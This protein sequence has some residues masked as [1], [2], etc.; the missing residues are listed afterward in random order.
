MKDHPIAT[1]GALIFNEKEEVLM[2]QTPKW[3]HLWGIPGGKIKR[4]ETAEEALI[5]EVKEETDLAI[6]EIRYI[7]TQDCIDCPEFFKPAHFLLMNYTAKTLETKV[8][9]NDEGVDYKWIQFTE[10]LTTP[11]IKL[12]TPTRTLLETVKELGVF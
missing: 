3:S 11:S 4:G 9:L 5:R 8:V 10:V 2:I 6:E 7:Q 1:V 12:N